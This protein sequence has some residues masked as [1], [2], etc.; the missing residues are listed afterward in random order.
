MSCGGNGKTITIRKNV[1]SDGSTTGQ[2]LTFIRLLL[3]KYRAARVTVLLEGSS[4]LL[5]VTAAG[6]Y[7]DTEDGFASASMVDVPAS[8]TTRT[9]DG[10]SYGASW[11][12]FDVTRQMLELGVQVKNTSGTK[13]QM[14]TVTLI[15]DLSDEA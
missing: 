2:F 7:S 12:T 15:I 11:Y 8:P 4:G 10:I 1:F 5:T 14:G 9:A 6:I 13:R 3:G